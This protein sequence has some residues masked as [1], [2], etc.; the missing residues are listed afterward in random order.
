MIRDDEHWLSTVDAL[1]SA[2]VGVQSW[3]TALQSF[4]DATGSRSA[5]LAGFDSNTALAF[6]IMA[7]VDPEI[8]KAVART[9]PSLP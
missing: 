9:V 1:Q 8:S 5:Q 3:E 7:N 4:A 2:A 6:N